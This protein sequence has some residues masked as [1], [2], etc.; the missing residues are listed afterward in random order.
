MLVDLDNEQRCF[1]VGDTFGQAVVDTGCPRTV[2]GSKWL[3]IHMNTLSRKD[4]M[5]VKNRQSMNSF[6]F[7][8]GTLYP[9]KFHCTVPVYIDN[10]RYNLGV[11]IVECN[12]PLLLSRET[13]GRAKAKID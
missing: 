7:G 6:R 10:C 13:L 3:Q 1:L 8:D 4:K 11:D 2:A 5:T 12:I 9:S